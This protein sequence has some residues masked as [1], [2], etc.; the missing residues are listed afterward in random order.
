MD[1]LLGQSAFEDEREYRVCATLMD[2]MKEHD[3][4]RGD[5]KNER[6]RKNSVII[7]QDN[8]ADNSLTRK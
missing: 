8:E 4:T 6:E 3:E 5:Y 7:A 1:R 2:R